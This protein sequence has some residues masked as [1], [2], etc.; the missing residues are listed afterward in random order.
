VPNSDWQ[1]LKAA[2]KFVPGL[3][4]TDLDRLFAAL[5]QFVQKLQVR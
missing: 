4:L 5:E 3:A 1:V 2:A